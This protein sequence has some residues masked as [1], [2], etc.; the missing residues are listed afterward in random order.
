M[1]QIS[2]VGGELLRL[3]ARQQHAMVERVPES[4][5]RNPAFLVDEG[6]VDNRDLR[7]VRQSSALKCTA[8]PQTPRRA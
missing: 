3:G 7:R 6:A 1:R 5:F 8:R 4:A 2:D